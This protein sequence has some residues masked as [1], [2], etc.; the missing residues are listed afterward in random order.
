VPKLVFSPDATAALKLF[1]TK[2]SRCHKHIHDTLYYLETNPGSMMNNR[3]KYQK[4]NF[5]IIKVECDNT[6]WL[7]LWETDEEQNTVVRYI[8]SA[9]SL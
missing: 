7:I 8:V 1:T 9:G 3:R 4:V 5:N 2:Y 6:V